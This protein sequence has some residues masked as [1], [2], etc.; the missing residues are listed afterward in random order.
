MNRN[1][2][3][4]R[5]ARAL[6]ELCVERELVVPVD[7]EMRILHE[8]LGDNKTFHSYIVN[9]AINSMEKFDHVNKLLAPHFNSLSIDFLKLVFQ[10][11]REFYLTDI[12]R[13]AIEM[14]REKQGVVTAQ[15]ELAIMPSEQTQS[16]IKERF[17]LMMKRNIEMT[18]L[19]NPELI[20]GFIFTL[21]GYRYDA[22]ISTQ[23]KLLS[24]ELH[25]NK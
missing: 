17:E 8:L 20:G 12:T 4:V 7:N 11:N 9:P 14:F 23:I 24:R 21:N 1:A 15:L 6:F 16:K 13:N 25:Q 19:T 22:S 5:Y 2:I 10:H 3:T 18:T